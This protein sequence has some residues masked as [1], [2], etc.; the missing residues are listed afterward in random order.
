[1]IRKLLRG[2]FHIAAILA[3]LAAAVIMTM[4]I[5]IQTKIP[6]RFYVMQGQEFSVK[7]LPLLKEQGLINY[8]KTNLAGK[9]TGASQ[10]VA[11]SLFGS[12][13]VTTTHVSVIDPQ[14]VTPG[15]TAFGIKLFTKGVMIIDM[16]NVDTPNGLVC[17][18]KLAGLQKGD[19]VLSVNGRE[20]YTNEELSSIIQACGGLAV[21]ISFSRNGAVSTTTLAPALSRSENSFKGGLWVRDS[22]AGIGTVTYYNRATGVFA[23]LG[24][25][26]C[27]SDTGKI[28]PLS[29]GE[30]CDV[31]INGVIKGKS[32]TPGEIRGSFSSPRAHG[33]L[34]LNNECGIFG[35]LEDSPNSFDS[36]PV[37][38]KQDVHTGPA[39]ILCSLSGD[40]IKSYSINIDKIDLNPSTMTKNMTITVTDPALLEKTGGIIQG[41]S[42]SPILQDNMLVGAVTHVFVNNPSRGYGIFAENMLN[43]S[44]SLF[45]KTAA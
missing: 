9:N 2:F 28:M 22:S 21:Q 42:G 29:T 4:V 38:L 17:P 45:E 20:I 36:V 11:L 19:I 33:K 27:D 44:N 26:I 1:M 37:K 40:G 23:G 24:H 5:Y 6:D 30:V 41:M 18:G 32:G 35:I 8:S 15:G 12:I 34:Y 43:F 3:L 13:P 7:N 10:T 39:M 16:N 25:G 14:E 31:N